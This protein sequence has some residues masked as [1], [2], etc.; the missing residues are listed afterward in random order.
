MR[1]NPEKSEKFLEEFGQHLGAFLKPLALK[2]HR[3]ASA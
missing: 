1:I 3:D 2:K